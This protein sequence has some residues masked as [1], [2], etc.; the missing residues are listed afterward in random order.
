MFINVKIDNLNE[1]SNSIPFKLNKDERIS[2]ENTKIITVKKYLFISSK[3]KLIWVNINL[4][5]KIF[6]GLLKDK[7][8][9]IE[10][11]NNEKILINLI[12]ELVEKKDPPIITNIKNINVKFGWFELSENPM[13]EILL[14]TDKRLIKK[15]LLKLKKRRKIAIITI[16]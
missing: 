2:K 14:D 9:L 12:P 3:S 13:L 4:F 7:I 5:I 6:L 15:L 11:L 16:K 8:W 10:Y 1:F